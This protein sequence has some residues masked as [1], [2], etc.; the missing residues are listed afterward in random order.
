MFQELYNEIYQPFPE[1]EQ[2]Q[3]CKNDDVLVYRVGEEKPQIG[4]YENF[5]ERYIYIRD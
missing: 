1:A 4:L 5:K 3:I 2:V